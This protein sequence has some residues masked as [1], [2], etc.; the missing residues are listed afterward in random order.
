MAAKVSG[1]PLSPQ[2]APTPVKIPLPN[3]VGAVPV[4]TIG[5]GRQAATTS[6]AAQARYTGLAQLT[7]G[8]NATRP[9]QVGGVPAG[10]PINQPQPTTTGGNAT[11]PNQV[12]GVPAGQP[13]PVVKTNQAVIPITDPNKLGLADQR[14]G[15][16]NP[17]VPASPTQWPTNAYVSPYGPT[18]LT[19]EL[20]GGPQA[21]PFT[22]PAGQAGI[23]TEPNAQDAAAADR[24]AGM[25][26]APIVD[27]NDPKY[28]PLV[29]AH[30]NPPMPRPI[31]PLDMG[32]GVIVQAD[33]NSYVSDASR[34]TGQAFQYAIDNNDPAKRPNIISDM[35]AAQ[36][37][38][39]SWGYSN[40]Q[41]FLTGMGYAWDEGLGV[42]VRQNPAKV[43]V[44]SGYD[45]AGQDQGTYNYPDYGY[46]G[47]GYGGPYNFG[48]RGGGGGNAFA[49]LIRWNIRA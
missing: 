23:T 42:W 11:K 19:N 1:S 45:N 25:A 40:P 49:G 48:S 43:A 39:K 26:G 15:E 30:G 14:A 44:S 35:I 37:P 18:G 13:L 34:W 38:Y 4:P 24:W 46:G 47:Y 6:P 32:N 20:G 5:A 33:L 3:Q 21:K 8:G 28:K 31:L 17:V 9:D 10:T 36:L 41:D 12:G 29:D 22:P 27:V 7:T 2:K 16:I